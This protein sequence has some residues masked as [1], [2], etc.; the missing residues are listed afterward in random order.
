MKPILDAQHISHQFKQKGSGNDSENFSIDQT[1]KD[2]SL[3]VFS[4]E[5]L[6]IIGTSGAG[7]S[8]LL[9]ILSGV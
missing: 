1:L 4:A 6:G 5:I 7:K 9:K 2:V 3:S 8:T